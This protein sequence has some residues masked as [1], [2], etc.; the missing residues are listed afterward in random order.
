MGRPRIYNTEVIV[1]RSRP[2]GEAD[3]VL[4]LITPG[5][6][7]IEAK[8]RGV[9]KAASKLGG[10]LEPL[11][12]SSLTLAKGQSID[13]VTGAES[14]ETFSSVKDSLERLARG[15]YLTELVDAL[16]PLDAPLPAVY[17]LF[18]ECLRA[19]G[20]EGDLDLVLRYSELQLLI[21]S[22]FMP[23]LYQCTEC[24]SLIAPHHHFLSP[25]AGGA[26]CPACSSSYSDA[27]G[28]SLN[29]M[30]VLRFLAAAR[31][32]SAIPLR[33]GPP[34]HRELAALMDSYLR[35]TLERELRSAAFLRSLS[36][37]GAYAATTPPYPEA[38]EA[39]ANNG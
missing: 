12:R 33:V 39:L 4:T 35:Y 26:L 29:A 16:S 20:E 30:K 27:M 14:L 31:I 5:L 18:L 36:P 19:L 24:H 38:A 32:T 17:D 2:L 13:T 7:K 8:A 21:H 9:R 10:H 23:E 1:L 25:Q 37:P 22:G 34:L 28:L 6:G 3:R 11:T 15:I